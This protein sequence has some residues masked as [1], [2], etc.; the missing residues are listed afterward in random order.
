MERA[1]AYMGLEANTPLDGVPVD[2]ARATPP[3]PPSTAPLLP[4]STNPLGQCAR[5]HHLPLLFPPLTCV[6]DY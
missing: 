1:L 4:V 2:K 3:P 6:L 5:L